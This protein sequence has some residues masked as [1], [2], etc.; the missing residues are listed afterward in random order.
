MPDTVDV[1]AVAPANETALPV[2]TTSNQTQDTSPS[3]DEQLMAVWNK[4]NPERDPH[5]RFAA[6]ENS[7]TEADSGAQ[8]PAET[9]AENTADQT[10]EAK[11]EQ[12][13][14]SAIEAPL[15]WSAEQKAKW[16]SVPPELQAYIAQRDKEQHEAIS[17]AGQQVKTFEPISKVV[18]HFQE[19]FRRNNLQ[20]ADA[21]ERLLA[22]E[23]S[24]AQN[25][26]NAIKD[27]AKAYGVDLRTLIDGQLAAPQQDD[28]GQ[29]ADPAVATLQAELAEVRA[30]NEKVMSYLTAQQRAQY[31]H[32][33]TALA[34]QIADF[35]KDK[36]HFEAVRKHMGALLQADENLTLDQAY[37]QAT[38]AV[39]EIRQRILADQRK[40]DED[41]RAEEARKKAADA[42]KSA[43][44]NVNS[45]IAGGNTPKTM[46]DTLNEI[47]RR[48]Y[49]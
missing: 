23:S 36:P 17:R 26:G 1:G 7:A 45:S 21:I 5:G 15:S 24:L 42:K 9:A 44:V 49:G 2:D 46:D 48:R 28:K 3:I 13:Q 31:E 38:Y 34:R 25:P 29:Q 10:A 8:E 47:A 32:E 20:P 30:N 6:R 19:T 11:P 40:A 27:I 4:N 33:Q 39:P 35:A 16:G 41:K 43:K 18:E 22:V 12:T 37:E 14:V